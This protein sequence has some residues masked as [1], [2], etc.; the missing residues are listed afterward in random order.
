MEYRDNGLYW[1]K[2]PSN[3]H[4]IIGKRIGTPDWKGY[5]ITKIKNKQYREH[6]LVWLY[7]NGYMPINQID[8][9]N[10][11]KDDNSIE[12]LRECSNAE[13]HQNKDI[14]SNNTSGYPGVCWDN[15]KQSWLAT[16]TVN[17]KQIY[18][19]VYDDI[20]NA[21][22]SRQKAEKQYFMRKV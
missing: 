6:H 20:S 5:R 10:R 18:L 9:I 3:G 7:H 1:K 2:K 8:H 17:R 14:Q 21:I 13:N 15:N 19:G 11:I 4:N 16:I 22:E 12:N